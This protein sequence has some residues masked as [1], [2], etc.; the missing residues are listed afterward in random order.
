MH[1]EDRRMRSS[2]I[3]LDLNMQDIMGIKNMRRI[4]KRADPTRKRETR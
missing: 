4:R 1:A 2:D 3:V